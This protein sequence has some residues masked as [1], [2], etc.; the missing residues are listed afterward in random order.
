MA[1]APKPFFGEGLTAKNSVVKSGDG[2][3]E[4]GVDDAE[5]GGLDIDSIEDA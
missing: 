5:D 3:G 2:E 1:N 4:E